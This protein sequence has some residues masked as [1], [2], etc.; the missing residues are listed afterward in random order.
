MIVIPM[1]GLSQRFRDAGFG[2]P[3]YMLD[4]HGR[5]LFSHTVG[6][7]AAFFASEEFL[8]IARAEA[9]TPSFVEQEATAL[10]VEAFRTVVLPHPT[11]GQ[12][13]TVVQGLRSADISADEPLTIF[14]IDTIRPG[15][16]HPDAAWMSDAAGYLEVMRATDPGFSYARPDP[17]SSDARVLE[18]VEKVVI[19]D[20]ASTGLYYFR[21][22]GLFLDAF[23][24]QASQI[25]G[26]ELYVAPLYNELIAQGLGVHYALVSDR[27]VIFCGTPQQYKSLLSDPAP[28]KGP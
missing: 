13:D 11:R 7:F 21:S 19:S 22:A 3:K 5:S 28:L 10:G 27:E 20:L 23:A 24:A 2:V 26:Q 25:G 16:R 8:F 14:N 18:T 6:S 4:L 12:A 9:D 15:F 1:A 17:A